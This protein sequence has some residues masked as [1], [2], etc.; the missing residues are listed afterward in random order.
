M[1]K[2][3]PAAGEAR[4][5]PE[6][7]APGARLTILRKSELAQALDAAGRAVQH[8]PGSEGDIDPERAKRLEELRARV[9]AGR[10]QPDIRDV[11]LGLIRDDLSPFA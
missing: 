4:I 5:R 10:Y 2:R 9:R 3:K 7:N 1:T 8:R 6:R 11:A